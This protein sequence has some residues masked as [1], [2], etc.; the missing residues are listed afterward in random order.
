MSDLE[1]GSSILGRG[2][3]PKRTQ[4]PNASGTDSRVQCN[5]TRT[6]VPAQW[7]HQG[8]ESGYLGPWAWVPES[9]GQWDHA[10]GGEVSVLVDGRDP[11][12][13]RLLR[14]PFSQSVHGESRF[15][16]QVRSTVSTCRSAREPGRRFVHVNHQYLKS[17]SI[18]GAVRE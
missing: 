3:E 7:V 5:R 13:I 17:I 10:T 14:L 16:L 4:N 6:W 12:P 2:N 9:L 11:I 15:A 1:V 18:L 8:S